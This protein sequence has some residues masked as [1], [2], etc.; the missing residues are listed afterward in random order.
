MILGGA[1]PPKQ[2]EERTL[3]KGDQRAQIC[4]KALPKHPTSLQWSSNEY[5][6]IFPELQKM[7]P[8][9]VGISLPLP[10]LQQFQALA[11][12]QVSGIQAGPK[13]RCPTIPWPR[14]GTPAYRRP[15]NTLHT[16]RSTPFPLPGK[17]FSLQDMG[18]HTMVLPTILSD[19]FP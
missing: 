10:R 16:L 2:N 17:S 12:P 18:F 5:Q 3:G 11:W 8:Q 7:Q 19:V 13:R 1:P 9:L 14:Q 15:G 6:V 4:K